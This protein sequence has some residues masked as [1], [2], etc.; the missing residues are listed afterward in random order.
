MIELKIIENC[1]P[2]PVMHKFGALVEKGRVVLV[3]FDHEVLTPGKPGG[4]REVVGHPAD[5]EAGVSTTLLQ[6]PGQ[7]R[8]GSGLAMGSGDGQDVPP[9]EHLLGKPLRPGYIAIAPVE[10]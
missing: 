3:R 1:R 6:D 2:W 5:Q 7:H 9:R 4:Y 8:R 10:D